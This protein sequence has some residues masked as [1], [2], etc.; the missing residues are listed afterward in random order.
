V[1]AQSYILITYDIDESTVAARGSTRAG[2]EENIHAVV[3]IVATRVNTPERT[4]QDFGTVVQAAA[5]LHQRLAYLQEG[6]WLL[7]YALA[8]GKD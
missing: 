2:K 8:G 7:G 4:T 1:T 6:R 5:P 3:D